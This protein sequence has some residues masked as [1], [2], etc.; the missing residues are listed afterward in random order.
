LFLSIPLGLLLDVVY[1]VRTEVMDAE[2]RDRFDRD[3]EG[4]DEPEDDGPRL[5]DQQGGETVYVRR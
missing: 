3:L 2:E 5:A 4:D 1:M